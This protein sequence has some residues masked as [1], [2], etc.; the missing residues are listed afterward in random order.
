MIFNRKYKERIALL[1]LEMQVLVKKVNKIDSK[2]NDIEPTF[3]NPIM[4]YSELTY[5][6]LREKYRGYTV[7]FNDGFD[8]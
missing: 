5:E 8:N 1:E 3:D 7:N 4:R 2:S 6:G